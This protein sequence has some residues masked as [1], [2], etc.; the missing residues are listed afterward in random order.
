MEEIFSFQLTAL[1]PGRLCAQVSLAL[2]KRTETVSRQKNPKMWELVDKLNGAEKVSQAVREKRKKRRTFL[3]LVNWLLGVFL[4][5][6]GLMDPK[7]LLLPLIVG[8]VGFGAGT[9]I[10]WRNWRGVL[11]ILNLLMG[12]L[13][14]WGGLMNVQQLGRLLVLGAAGVVIGFAALLTRK[15]KKITSF[16]RAARKLL[17]ERA[18][19]TGME[20]V[21]V[22]FSNQGMT[23]AQEGEEGSVVGWDSFEIVLET[24]DLLLPVF[25]E[26]VIILQKSD[27]LAGTISGLRAL[28]EQKVPYVQTK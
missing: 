17:D 23:V 5:L 4:L 16:D 8:A 3:G 20:K 10:L 24:E 27:L 7:T 21:R 25:Q 18:D 13:L 15:R 28:L 9:V 1:D 22:T 19:R 14:C 12:G 6:P 26:A 2:E 11:G